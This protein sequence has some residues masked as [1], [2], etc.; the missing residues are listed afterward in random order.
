[1]Q[2]WRIL[3]N[4]PVWGSL[5]VVLILVAL[6]GLGLPKHYLNLITLS[7]IIGLAVLGLDILMGY[8]GLLSLGQ[9]GFMAIGAYTTAIL[10]VRYGL[11]PLS[12]LLVAQIVTFLTSIFIGKAVLRLRGYHLAIATLAFC[13]IMEQL[14]VNLRN[15]TGGPSGLAGIPNFSLGG[16]VI[17]PGFPL[18]YLSMGL[19]IIF[20]ILL[21]NLMNCR[22]GRAWKARSG[23][24]LAASMLGIDLDKYKLMAFTF[25]ACLA[26]LSGSLY[27]HYMHFISPEMVGMQTSFNLVVMTALGGSGTLWGPLLGVGVLT[28]LPDVI[29]FLKDFQLIIN[30][31]IL[32]LAMVF[33][34]GGLAGLLSVPYYLLMRT[35]VERASVGKGVK[36]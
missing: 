14:L 24:E 11:A 34:P 31:V 3:S 29:S 5:V 13:V 2:K 20:F 15:L 17:G 9:A 21:K 25:S 18:Y 32:L 30:G 8:T 19:V 4:L 22:V 6:P 7:A 36:K 33:F 35:S 28:F 26:T 16:W 1:M 10:T 12:A 23:D 27:A